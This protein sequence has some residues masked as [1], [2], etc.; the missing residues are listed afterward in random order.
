MSA[1]ATLR[2]LLPQQTELITNLGMYAFRVVRVLRYG[3]DGS[4]PD[5]AWGF[6]FVFLTSDPHGKTVA[7][8]LVIK[9]STMGLFDTEQAEAIVGQLEGFCGRTRMPGY[10]SEDYWGDLN[11]IWD[12]ILPIEWSKYR[13][14]EAGKITDRIAMWW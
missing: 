2:S 5:A 1:A 10:D 13:A 6:H 9:H 14:A 4:D 8:Q 11:Y 7:D 12:Q 3:T